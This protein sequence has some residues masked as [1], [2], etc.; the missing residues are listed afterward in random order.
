MDKKQYS[1]ALRNESADREGVTIGRFD[2]YFS[3]K[4][5]NEET[6]DKKNIP[7]YVRI[8]GALFRSKF[9]GGNYSIFIAPGVLDNSDKTNP[10]RVDYSG[11]SER[12]FFWYKVWHDPSLKFAFFGLLFA[13]IGALID[14]SF[15]IGKFVVW[16]PLSLTVT[17]ILYILSF[18]LKI[19]GLW[20]V[21][22][23]GFR[24]AK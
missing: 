20:W 11:A 14:T 24:D 12:A 3:E 9:L 17:V 7:P 18:L 2:A 6:V 22:K 15:A 8:E 16:I 13:I 23:K 10:R 5:L 19:V 4:D 21:F 1:F